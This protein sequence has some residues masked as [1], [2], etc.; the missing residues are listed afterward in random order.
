MIFILL[1]IAVG[2][3]CALGYIPL[4]DAPFN[5]AST[6]V[7]N[8]G[9]DV[10][11]HL[12]AHVP[13]G[14]KTLV[15]ALGVVV[16]VAFPGVLSMVLIAGARFGSLLRRSVA[17]LLAF[18]SIGVYFVLPM[19]QAVVASGALGALAA[20]LF[21]FTGVVV[22]APLSAISAGLAVSSARVLVAGKNTAINQGV[23]TLCSV[24]HVSDPLVWRWTLVAVAWSGFL[25]AAGL[26]LKP[27]VLP[28]S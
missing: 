19:H 10:V 27:R 4:L 14:H 16:G 6:W 7:V 9:Q 23:A 18:G 15:I 17:A 26:A 13:P 28:K 22:V 11:A 3:A 20:V 8:R 25:G 5:A 12:M 1:G 21:L 24:T 2:A